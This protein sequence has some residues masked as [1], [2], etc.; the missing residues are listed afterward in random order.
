MMSFLVPRGPSSS[1]AVFK[2]ASNFHSS[3]G[4]PSFPSSALKLYIQ[5]SPAPKI[6]CGTPW[7]TATAGLDHWPWRMLMPGEL[8]CQYT[9]PVIL[10]IARKLGALGLGAV[11]CCS[12]RPLPVLTNRMSP[13]AVT[14]QEHMLCCDVP[15][16]VI[17]L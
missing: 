16:L 3:S 13:S 1:T 15:R 6:T 2:L 5:P 12:S 11:V 4:L 17:M 10:F 7:M 9:S 14:E 8:S